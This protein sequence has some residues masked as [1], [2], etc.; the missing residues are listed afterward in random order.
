MKAKT[1]LVYIAII[2]TMT[3]LG[4]TRQVIAVEAEVQPSAA[5]DITWD[6]L[7]PDG[8][9]PPAAQI[10]HFFDAAPPAAAAVAESPVVVAMDQVRVRLPG[11][12]VPLDV[13]GED[14]KTFLMVP[15]FGACVHVPPPPPNQVVYVEMP[16]AVQLDDPYGAHWVTGV[17]TTRTSST[18][19]AEASY[20]MAGEIVEV[21]DWDKFYEQSNDE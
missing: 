20:S 18:S 3:G 16:H 2:L 5:R 19:M 13:E 4:T 21:F 12:L 10:D 1:L 9:V 15:Y 7:I 6:D 14:L 11:Y 17:I 8:W